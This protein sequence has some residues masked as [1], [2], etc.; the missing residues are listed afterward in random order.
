M[1]VSKLRPRRLLTRIGLA[2]VLLSCIA[3]PAIPQDPTP[4]PKPQS[5]DDATTRKMKKMAADIQPTVAKLRGMEWKYEVPAGIYRREQLQSFL[6]DEM[7][8][9]K[10]EMQKAGLML[11]KMGMVPKGF[12]MYAATMK[13]Y[14]GGIA[15]FYD[16]QVKELNLVRD[17]KKTQ[18]QQM[19]EM[20]MQMM[21]GVSNDQMVTAH[22][23]THALDDQYYDLLNLIDH[24]KSTSDDDLT[25]LAVTEGTA[26]SVQYDFL[27]A[28]QGL[29]SYDNPT[30]ASMLDEVPG[31]GS[32][33]GVDDSD[34]PEMMIKQ[35]LWPYSVGNRLVFEARKRENGGWKAVNGM[36][37]DMP[38]S[39]EQI[40][41]PE[42]YLDTPRDMP[43]VID[44]PDAEAM[45]ALYG[46]GWEE[47]D[48][49]TYG[50]FQLWIYLADFF[51][52]R[53]SGPE[54]AKKVAAGWDGDTM[55]FMKK[56]AK[57]DETVSLVWASAWDSEGDAIE[58]FNLYRNLLQAKYNRS[59]AADEEANTTLYR[60][61]DT[62]ASTVRLERRGT[63]V[64]VLE[65]VPQAKEADLL[66][67]WTDAKRHQWSRPP[68][69][70]MVPMRDPLGFKP[71]TSPNFSGRTYTNAAS[72]LS[73]TL[74]REGHLLLSDKEDG[75]IYRTDAKPAEAR[76]VGVNTFPVGKAKFIE[77]DM[78]GA[79][80]RALMK[81]YKTRTVVLDKEKDGVWRLVFGAAD[82]DGEYMICAQ[83]F[84][85]GGK[86]VCVAV[87]VP[88]VA[89][90]EGA[91]DLLDLVKSIKIGND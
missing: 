42:K 59:A 60:F 73:Y 10:V 11:A 55:V 78:W 85:V 39:T 38:A 58:F 86:M 32:I 47:L 8:G 48:R 51:R 25:Q 66:K 18:A 20:M 69:D 52:D 57:G 83:A 35:V 82:H 67:A 15:G 24:S 89:F 27:F 12:D 2:A 34:L 26:T 17:T 63:E 37:E 19:E 4:Q 77:E 72:G 81:G 79:F 21:L 3:L 54:T 45:A 36:F 1:I 87:Q 68:R 49:D 31:R 71:V 40:L 70:K 16:P 46:E 50:E 88:K 80:R 43:V 13:L 75:Q 9:S 14:G 33:P 84:E 30:L 23:L 5:E 56:G 22:E 90:N 64:L 28:R 76:W 91:A 6:K 44:L 29:K 41:H 74:P 53:R 65:T 61:N 62:D 7:E